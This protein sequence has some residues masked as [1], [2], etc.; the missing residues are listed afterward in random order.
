MFRLFALEVQV[1][2]NKRP[3]F[4]LTVLQ[5]PL[6][7]RADAF[8]KVLLHYGFTAGRGHVV[9]DDGPTPTTR[10]VSVPGNIL[11]DRNRQPSLQCALHAISPLSMIWIT[12]M[13]IKQHASAGEKAF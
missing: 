10:F 12:I 1:Q 9:N 6:N 11:L 4:A 7:N 5:G 3:V 13:G 2:G 8:K